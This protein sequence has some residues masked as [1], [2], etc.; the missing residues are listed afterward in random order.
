MRAID[1]IKVRT[2]FPKCEFLATH[3]W[4]WDLLADE[5]EKKPALAG[6]L[7]LV[8]VRGYPPRQMTRPRT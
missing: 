2:L 7:L 6:S 5:D 3:G 8:S 1:K 4:G